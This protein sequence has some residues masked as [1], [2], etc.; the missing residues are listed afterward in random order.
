MELTQQRV[1]ELFDYREDGFLISKI[2]VGRRKA[3]DP[4]GFMSS[5]GYWIFKI[6][7]KSIKVHRVIF[8]WHYGYI[9]AEVDHIDCDRGN[10]RIENLRAATSQENNR[11]RGANKNNTSGFKGVAFEADRGKW[12]AHICINRKKMHLGRFD[13]PEAAHEAY[14]AAALKHFGEFA[15]AA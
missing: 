4:I 10:N 11:N 14:K 3:G 2:R 1:R 13:S 9:P 15:R 5:L 12:K 7:K 8:L 6:D